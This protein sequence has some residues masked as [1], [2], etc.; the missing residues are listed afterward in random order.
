MDKSFEEFWLAYPRKIAK[1]AA[2]QKWQRINMTSELFEKIM[3][4][5]E[6]QKKLPQWRKDGG[7]YIPHP[8]T[9]LNQER[10]EDEI[11]S[12]NSKKYDGFGESLSL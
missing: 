6:A 8:A 10:W 1:K 7:Q 5:V 4:A 12:G 11:D 3:K 2:R 9:W